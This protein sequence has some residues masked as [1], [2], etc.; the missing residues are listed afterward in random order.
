VS[1]LTLSG[2]QVVT[3][4]DKIAGHAPTQ[5]TAAAR[6]LWSATAFNGRPGVVFDGTDDVLSLSPDPLATGAA[7]EELWALC[8]PLANPTGRFVFA[9]G[10]GGSQARRLV[11]V[12]GTNDAVLG[13]GD[14]AVAQSATI[15]GGFTG[16]SLLRAV[17]QA[18]EADL[19]LNGGSKQTVAVVPSTTGTHLRIG[20]SANSSASSFWLGPINSIM[21]T[22]LLTDEQAASLTTYFKTR[23]GIA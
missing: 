23:G 8:D 13:V 15:V 21:A 19:Y 5:A 9:H 16:P 7:T 18:T 2:S 6:P 17:I 10:F 3:W 14:G 12:M 1:T 20:A 4:A 11:R 22:A